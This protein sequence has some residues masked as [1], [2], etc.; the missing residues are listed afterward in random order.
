MIRNRKCF[1]NGRAAIGFDGSCWIPVDSMSKDGI[2]LPLEL[3][4]NLY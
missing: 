1:G 2:F 3:V 4:I